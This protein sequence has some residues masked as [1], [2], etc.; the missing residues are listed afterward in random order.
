MAR[1]PGR[2]LVLTGAQAA[3]KTTVGAALAARLPR[4]IHVDGDV[5]Q[6]LVRS[7]AVPMGLPPPP[8]ALLQLR[9]RYA[10]SFAV[11]GVYRHAGFDAIV[12]DNIFGA[13]LDRLLADLFTH[14]PDLT[15]HL[16]VLDPD[17]AVIAQRER[18]RGKK[19]YGESITVEKLFDA[20]R[21]DTRRLGLWLDTGAM[22]VDQ[23]VEAVLANW[24]R[25]SLTRAT[26]TV[27]G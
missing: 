16:V 8:G 20:V 9:L 23:A 3:G 6:G 22:S 24:S 12:T 5:I 19:G 13:E 1:I 14:D 27:L 7:G 4:A 2:L 17:A 25:S 15:L 18:D 11:A 21:R 26:A 10:A